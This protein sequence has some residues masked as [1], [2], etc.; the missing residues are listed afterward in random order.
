MQATTGTMNV[1]FEKL[2]DGPY[3][4]AL[5]HDENE[6]YDLNLENGQPIEG[7]GTSGARGMYDDPGFQQALVKPGDVT[8][9]MY[10]LQ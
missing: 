5:F 7:Y 9:Q 6:D 2:T 4:I 1:P 8:V 10:Y 3:A